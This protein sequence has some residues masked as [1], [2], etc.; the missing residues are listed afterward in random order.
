MVKTWWNNET[1]S[2]LFPAE[3]VK[4]VL[5][6]FDQERGR[7]GIKG[8]VAALEVSMSGLRQFPRMPT[9]VYHWY[10][11][12]CIE[13]PQIYTYKSHKGPTWIQKNILN[14]MLSCAR[15]FC[16]GW[17]GGSSFAGLAEVVWGSQSVAWNHGWPGFP[18]PWGIALLLWSS[19]CIEVCFQKR[20]P[21][22][23]WPAVVRLY[24][25][26]KMRWWFLKCMWQFI[27][28]DLM[29]LWKSIHFFSTQMP[30]DI[31]G[32]IRWARKSYENA[33]SCPW[34]VMKGTHAEDIMQMKLETGKLRAANG[35]HHRDTL[36][37]VD[38]MK[39]SDPLIHICD[40][41]RNN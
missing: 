3:S 27:K 9:V 17:P 16:F 4:R 2:W 41:G 33:K 6:L 5:R 32:S 38:L 15:H 28:N 13:M 22:R 37:L 11:V 7:E 12:K 14:G 24:R 39:D 26:S 1:D 25:T 23:G 20:G 31:P 35:E 36:Y 18:C 29:N 34:S 21:D 30:G 40:V 19:P 8:F 10:A